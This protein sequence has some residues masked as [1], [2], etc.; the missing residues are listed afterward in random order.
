MAFKIQPAIVMFMQR[1]WSLRSPHPEYDGGDEDDDG[2]SGGGGDGNGSSDSEEDDGEDDSDDENDKLLTSISLLQL[3]L[4]FQH[5]PHDGQ[6]EF[7][8]SFFDS[9]VDNNT[10]NKI[11]HLGGKR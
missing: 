10:C 7:E 5:R 2:D 11:H 1:A 4:L 3:K 6:S 9:L 8:K